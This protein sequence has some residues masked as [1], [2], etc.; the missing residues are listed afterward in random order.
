MKT[1]NLTCWIVT[2]GMKGTENQCVGIAETMG[3]TPIIKT[4]KLKSPWKQLA[5]YVCFATESS[6]TADSD[7]ISAP[8]PDILIVSGRKSICIAKHIKKQSNGKTFTICIQDPKISPKNFDLVVAPQHD[9]INGENVVK[10]V[11]T[12]NHVSKEILEKE[13]QK[14]VGK[15]DHL[16]TPKV[17]VL[18]GG[19]S[20]HH[21][22]NAANTDLLIEQL[23]KLDAGLMITASGRTGE[24]NTKKLKTSLTGDNIYFWDGKGDNPYFAFLAMADYILVTEDS[25]SMASE[26]LVTGKPVYIIELEGGGRRNDLFHKLLQDKGYTKPFT[27]ELE[28]WSYTPP[29]DKELAVKAIYKKLE[30]R[31]NNHG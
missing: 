14:F 11:G 21:T 28:M 12:V 24:E 1:Q 26:A 5:P 4:I 25:V 18:I 16:P 7:D 19:S 6:L 15:F 20:K 27:G 17:A 3:L 2:E 10:T 31:E 8:Y 30:E 23:Q 9:S 22:M 29:N 13:K